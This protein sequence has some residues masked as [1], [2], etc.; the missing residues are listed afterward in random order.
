[1]SCDWVPFVETG[2]IYIYIC[3][4]TVLVKKLL[5]YVK[6]QLFYKYIFVKKLLFYKNIYL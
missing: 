5:I 6:K 1:M 3:K 4:K 2:Y